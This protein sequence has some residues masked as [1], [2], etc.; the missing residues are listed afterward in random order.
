MHVS[1]KDLGTGKEQKITITVSGNLSEEEIEKA[2]NEAKKFEE[3]D[4]KKKESVEVRNN[5]DALV[6]QAEKSLKELG[7]KLSADDKS[8]IETEISNVKEVLKGEDIEAI[9]NASEKLS[10]AFYE[11]SSKIYQQQNPGGQ[12]P[13]AGP[14]PGADAGGQTDTGGQEQEDVYDADYKV[15]DEEEENKS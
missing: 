15:V 10:T 3:E 7:D 12:G 9:K 11:I 13:E 1:A 2:V 14:N 4:K 6:F 5:A 8:K